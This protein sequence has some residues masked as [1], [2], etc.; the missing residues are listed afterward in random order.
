[1]SVRLLCVTV[2]VL[3]ISRPRYMNHVTVTVTVGDLVRITSTKGHA[4]KTALDSKLRSDAPAAVDFSA[5]LHQLPTSVGD[6]M[7]SVCLFDCWI[8]CGGIV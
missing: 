3:G 6:R 8:N 1:M 4:L 2:T 7:T 5:Y